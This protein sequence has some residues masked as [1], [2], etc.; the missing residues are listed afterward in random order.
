MNNFITRSITG[1]LYVAVIVF[2]MVLGQWCFAGVMFAVAGVSLWEFFSIV[3]KKTNPIKIIGIISGLF[4]YLIITLFVIDIISAKWLMLIIVPIVLLFISALYLRRENPISDLSI[5]LFGICYVVVP[6]ALINQI[7]AF[8]ISQDMNYVLPLGFFVILWLNDSGA[9]LVGSKIGKNRLF[10]SVSPKKSWEGFVGGA[11]FAVGSSVVLATNF[12]EMKLIFWVIYAVII[13]IFATFG[14][15][16][17]SL[18]KRDLGIKDSGSI[19]PG[20]GGMLDRFDGV[21][22]SVPIVVFFLM[23]INNL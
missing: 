1:L 15:L 12:V 8:S 22:L 18:F 17:E 21:F 10:V 3:S 13:V 4:I 11:L 16:V 2:S 20:H 7:M 14:D 23:L 19:L 5:T 9:Y 6:L